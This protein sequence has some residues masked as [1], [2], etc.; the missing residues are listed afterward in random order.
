MIPVTYPS[1]VSTSKE[2]QMVVF[3]LPSVTGL[4]RWTDYIPVKLQATGADIANSFNTNG[5]LACD[6]LVTTTGKQAWIDYIPVFVDNAATTAWQVSETGFIPFNTLAGGGLYYLGPSLD[7]NFVGSL[8]N[9]LFASTAEDYTLNTN[10]LSLFY[11][12]EAQYSVQGPT[13]IEQKNFADIVTFTRASTGT[14]FNSA[15]TLTTAATNEARFDYNPSTLAARGLLIEESRTNSIRNNTMQ[16]ASTPSTIPTNW[17]SNVGGLTLGVVGTGTENGITYIDIRFSGIPTQTFANVRFEPNTQIVAA[18][19]QTW[20]NSFYVRRVAGS[21]TNITDI[22]NRVFYRDSGGT[23]TQEAASSVVGLLANTA[24]NVSK[25]TFTYVCSTATTAFVNSA[26]YLTTTVG[27]AIDITL[28][29]G[30]PQL[31]QGAFATSVI[32]TTTTALTRSADVASV[33]T[34]SPWYNSVEGTLFAEF[35]IPSAL[36]TG[37]FPRIFS[38]LGSGGPNVD[39]LF[40]YTI[41]SSGKA[42]SF[43]A[44]AASVNPGR[45]DASP[46]FTAD[47][48]IKS[49][50][51]YATN[52][53]AV[54]ANG[55]TPTTSATAYTIPTVTT[56]RLGMADS[57]GNNAINGYLRRVT[58]YPRRLSN[59]DLQAITA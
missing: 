25:T 2:S 46:T 6:F 7:L 1:S 59:A 13:G 43:N 31:E 58:Y 28:R 56:A 19:G 9:P 12:V 45:I 54:T 3:A 51:A 17:Q 53:R 16:G 14:Y 52:D 49:A 23:P 34:L 37:S 30:L 26:V 55:V 21:N 40:I 20:T 8:S 27:A 10:F 50:G 39:E 4:Q 5:Y 29:I 44:I 42:A 33:N 35:N 32:P 47:T 48:V 41:Q 57:F 36:A 22:D 38:L 18:N 15:G 11:Q 24:L